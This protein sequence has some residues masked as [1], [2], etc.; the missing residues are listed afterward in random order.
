MTDEHEKVPLALTAL[1]P[2]DGNCE[3]VLIATFDTSKEEINKA[4]K[5]RRLPA[6][7]QN[8]SHP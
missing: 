3:L 6:H 7:R 4:L 8:L 5:G 2:E 1:E